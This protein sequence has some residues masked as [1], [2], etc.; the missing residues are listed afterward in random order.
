MERRE[1]EMLGKSKD[2]NDRVPSPMQQ[3]QR[4]ATT[5]SG[6]QEVS[7]QAS[8]I[9]RGMTVVG[10]IF[11]ESTVQLFGRIEGELRALTVLI[12]EGVRR[13]RGGV[14]HLWAGQGDYPC[15]SRQV[16]QYRRGR[17]RYFSPIA[18]D[19]GKCAV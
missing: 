16:E 10:K 2:D 11:G 6:E 4:P 14:D 17:R 8:S 12:N 7:D 9:S 13:N 3:L 1:R 5:H 19:R 15:K 18:I